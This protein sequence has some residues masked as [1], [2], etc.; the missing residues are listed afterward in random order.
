VVSGKTVP[1]LDQAPLPPEATSQCLVP[2]RKDEPSHCTIDAPDYGDTFKARPRTQLKLRRIS[3]TAAIPVGSEGMPN[4][5]PHAPNTRAGFCGNPVQL[6][7]IPK[8]IRRS[9]ALTIPV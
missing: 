1:T 2:A 3:P 9:P 6:R 7:L 4:F 5:V 8:E